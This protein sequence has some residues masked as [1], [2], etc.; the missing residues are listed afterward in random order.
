MP[1][2]PEAEA[3]RRAI[4]RACLHRR[5]EAVDLGPDTSHVDLPDS[6]ARDRLIGHQFTAARR[7]GKIVFA[8]SQS[9]PWIAV[10]LGMTGRLIPFTSDED[11]S[12]Y[13][14][15]LIRLEG[16]QRLAFR[17]PR[18]FGSI[19]V[20]NDPDEFVSSEGIGPDALDT[21][22]KQFADITGDG[23]GALKPAL[24]DQ[25]KVAGLGNLWTDELLFQTGLAPE[26]A[27]RN[28]TDGQ[29]NDLHETMIDLLNAVA[30]TEIDYSQ[31][32]GTWLIHKRDDG[33]GCPRCSGTIRKSTV[34][35]RSTYA[36]DQH[37]SD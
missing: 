37:Q 1:E 32:P 9:G 3:N 23:R 4:E 18:K 31:L 27:R 35:G 21:S 30:D 5:I 20:V 26:K 10:H 16:D 28:L 36:C 15:L 14:R 34:G 22:A 2:L 25:K 33:A 13:S 8:G 12:E 6:D 24:M 17:C 29:L 11:P 7:H 19:A